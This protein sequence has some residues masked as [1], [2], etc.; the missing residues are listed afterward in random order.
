MG[1]VGAAVILFAA[2][3][4]CAAAADEAGANRGPFNLVDHDGQAVT[5]RD[6]LGRYVLIFFGYS[7]CP[8]ICPTS[9]AVMAAAIDSLGHAG[10]RVQP[11]FI[12]VDPARDTPQRLAAYAAHFHP[13]L[14]GLTGS[15]A[16]IAAAA[17]TYSARYRRADPDDAGPDYL[18]DH[19]G[20]IYL[21][22]PDG[23]GLALFPHD[24]SADEIA[25]VIRRFMTRESGDAAG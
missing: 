4:C 5:D 18:I 1:R 8:D 12:S 3:L 20:A 11:L 16:Q 15:P 23:G 22:G 21:L 7:H 25:A 6:Y 14:I 10:E 19:T 17:R 24:I 13:R 2:L 9:L